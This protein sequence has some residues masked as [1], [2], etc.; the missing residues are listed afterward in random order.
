MFDVYKIAGDSLYPLYFHGDYVLILKKNIFMNYSLGD[1]IVFYTPKK[2]IFIKIISK[3]DKNHKQLFVLG[4]TDV[5]Q[6]S[7]EFGWISFENVIGKLL[8]SFR[9]ASQKNS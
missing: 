7:R 4:T 8:F 9:K 5:S 1:V 6:D 2:E 3:L